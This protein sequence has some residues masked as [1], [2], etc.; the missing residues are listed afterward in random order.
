MLSWLFITRGSTGWNEELTWAIE[1]ATN[2]TILAEVYR[3]TP[4]AIIYYIWQERNH[5]IF[6]HKERNIDMI[7][8][9][10]IQGIHYRAR[11]AGPPQVAHPL[12]PAIR[13]NISETHAVV[14]VVYINRSF[15][16]S[17]FCEQNISEEIYPNSEDAHIKTADVQFRVTKLSIAITEHDN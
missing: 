7:S 14:I 4:A 2:K 16:G 17:D 1:H 11:G 15:R 12:L 13:R 8:R 6:Q 3:M 9:L 10:I 5:R